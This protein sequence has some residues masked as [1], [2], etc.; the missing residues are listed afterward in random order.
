MSLYI[1][2][3][4]CQRFIDKTCILCTIHESGKAQSKT[5]CSWFIE[6]NNNFNKQSVTS[7][8][9]RT[10]KKKRGKNE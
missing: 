9:N 5:I 10:E 6:A 2:G 3:N 8:N 4:N 1:D 7:K